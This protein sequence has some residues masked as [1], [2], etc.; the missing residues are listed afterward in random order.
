[1]SSNPESGNPDSSSPFPAGYP[2]P[3]ATPPAPVQMPAQMPM[4]S[5]VK[6]ARTMLFVLGGLQT[7]GGVLLTALAAVGAPDG[8]ELTRGQAY[9]TG[10]VGLVLG[11]A[12][13]VVAS[14]FRSGG[15]GVRIAAAVIGGLILANALISLAMGKLTGGPGL[16]LGALV[17]V[18]CLAKESAAWF[19]RPPVA[20]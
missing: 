14:R 18:N 9:A 6:T 5:R 19:R 4:P 13:F 8:Q 7:L 12:S 20:R 17:L 1:M 10:V 16:A 3:Y 11:V 15:N 2:A